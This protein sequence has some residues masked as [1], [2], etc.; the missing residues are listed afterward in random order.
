MNVDENV[1]QEMIDQ[2]DMNSDGLLD[3]NEFKLMMKKLL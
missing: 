1:W 2:V 3:F